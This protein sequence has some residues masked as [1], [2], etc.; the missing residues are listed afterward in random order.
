MYGSLCVSNMLWSDNNGK[1]EHSPSRAQNLQSGLDDPSRS[2]QVVIIHSWA[3]GRFR[4]GYGCIMLCL[5]ECHIVNNGK[6][7]LGEVVSD[8]V[9]SVGNERGV[10]L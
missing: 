7:T 2:D 3:S 4:L 6:W 1:P 5:R 9:L 8:S 10:V